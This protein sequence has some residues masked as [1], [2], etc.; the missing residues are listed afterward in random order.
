MMNASRWWFSCIVRWGEN[1]RPNREKWRQRRPVK[2]RCVIGMTPGSGTHLFPFPTAP[3]LES[4]N[5]KFRK[6][7]NTHC[8]RSRCFCLLVHLLNFMPCHWWDSGTHFPR[9][10][11]VNPGKNQYSFLRDHV[12][13]VCWCTG[14]TVGTGRPPGMVPRGEK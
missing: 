14:S 9:L 6:R 11:L 5:A 3:A 13:S 1:K 2:Q 8:E 10:P 4:M 7:V 12:V